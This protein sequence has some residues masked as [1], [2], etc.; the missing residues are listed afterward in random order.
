MSCEVSG[1]PRLLMPIGSA[2]AAAVDGLDPPSEDESCARAIV[3]GG[4]DRNPASRDRLI[5]DGRAVS[6][7][8]GPAMEPP[9]PG[10][11]PLRHTIS[12]FGESAAAA[13]R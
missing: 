12:D 6:A 2:D 13:T 9:T 10:S 7:E 1:P 4:A 8:L 11:A 3:D 5:A